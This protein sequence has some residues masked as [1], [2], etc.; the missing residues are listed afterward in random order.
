[1]QRP[2]PANKRARQR[3]FK[4]EVMWESHPDFAAFIDQSWKV[5]QCSNME[6][7]REK[8]ESLA[9]GCKR[10]DHD[11]FGEVRKEL[12]SL[13][14]RLTELREEPTRTGPS[15]EEIKTCDRIVELNHREEIMWCQRS[16]IQWLA[17]GDNNTKFF[18][19]KATQRRNKNKITELTMT[20]GTVTQDVDTMQS[21]TRD[22]YQHLYTAEGTQGMQTVLETV[23]RRVTSGM[24]TFLTAPYTGEEVKKALFQM[25]PTKAPGP[26]GFP[27]HFFQ[28]NWDLC[29]NEVTKAVLN[30]LNGIEPPELI[31]YTCIVLIP[32]VQSPKLL[33]QFRPIS[34]CNVILKIVSKVQANHLKEILS[35]IISDEQSAFVPGGA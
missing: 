22:F 28:R 30:I 13:H 35:E 9:G 8:L 19:Q 21:M 14:S 12:K 10:W 24:N 20:D 16:R 34:L 7:L 4:Y 2:L 3:T 17:D 5:N 33:T 25:F 26:D 18:H 6:E 15:Y 23:P 29:G 32:K 1:M 31:N 11:V 27:A